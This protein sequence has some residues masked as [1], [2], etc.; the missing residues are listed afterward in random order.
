MTFLSTDALILLDEWIVEY[1]AQLPALKEFILPSGTQAAAQAHVC[2]TVARRAERSIIALNEEEAIN[3]DT[4][5]FLNRCSDVFFIL[6]R[7]LNQNAQHP[8]IYWRG[9]QK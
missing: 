6:A 1:N 3:N 5:K 9:A 7:V 2:R 8:E 4:L